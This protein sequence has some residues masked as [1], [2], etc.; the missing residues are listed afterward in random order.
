MTIPE[1]EGRAGF[2]DRL[3]GSLDDC[4]VTRYI[5]P[6][7]ASI[8]IVIFIL[9]SV[10][11]AFCPKMPPRREKKGGSTMGKYLV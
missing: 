11:E 4:V 5:G 9:S 2:R 10:S 6:A 8:Y 7:A 3:G 1:L